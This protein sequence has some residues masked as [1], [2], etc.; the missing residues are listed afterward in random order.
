MLVLVYLVI[1][2]L[3]LVHLVRL[4][5]QVNLVKFPVTLAIPGAA[6][7]PPAVGAPNLQLLL[8]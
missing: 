6:D 5:L 4:L 2:V 3:D 7:D 8:L 1:Y